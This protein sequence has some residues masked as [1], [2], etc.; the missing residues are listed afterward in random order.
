MR[1]GMRTFRV[2]FLLVLA[3]ALALAGY[4]LLSGQRSSELTLYG[5]V[6]Q[7]QVELSFKDAERVAQVLVEEGALVEKGQVLAVLETRRLRDQLAVLAAQ[8]D[9][10]QA[11]LAKLENGTRP[12]EID[13]ARAQVL[14]GRADLEYAEKQY[15]RLWEILQHS[16]GKGAR[17]AD[18]DE[19][20]ARRDAAR[21]RLVVLE[22]ALRLAEIGPRAEDLAQARA[23]LA[24]R[25][26]AHK[27]L[28]NRLEDARL[29]SPCR[30]YVQ[31]RLLE[32]GDMASPDKAVFSLAVLSP[33]WVRAYVAE[34]DLG[35]IHQGMEA[36]IT[37]DSFPEGLTGHVGFISSVAEFTPK[38]VETTELRTA[39]VYEVRILVEDN[40]DR[41][42]L[43]MPASVTIAQARDH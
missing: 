33:K 32:P 10:A 12:E 1:G 23:L 11:A 28:Q 8:T 15:H 24:E 42:R 19:A 16:Q 3:L 21:A 43:G 34:P 25:R 13:Q 36:R 6:D 2:I 4:F 27:A 35:R 14:A 30:S 31:R 5:N 29:Q 9:E 41:L 38:T 26:L 40:E 18:L 39:L 37:T 17:K 20:L 22:K 7:R